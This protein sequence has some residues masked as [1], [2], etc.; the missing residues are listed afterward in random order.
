MTIT[1]SSLQTSTIAIRPSCRHPKTTC[2]SRCARHMIL[3]D[4]RRNPLRN[5]YRVNGRLGTHR[6]IDLSRRFKLRANGMNRLESPRFSAGREQVC[7]G[8]R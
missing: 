8:S 5:P 3:T 7:G 4:R 2:P 6:Y 1:A